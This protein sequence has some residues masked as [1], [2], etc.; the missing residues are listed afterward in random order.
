MDGKSRR[1]VAREFGLARKTISKMLEYSSPPGYRRQK[2]VRRPRLAAWQGVIDAI[3]EE[4][5]RRPKKQRHAAKRIFE[6]LKSEHAY[7]GGYTIMTVYVRQSRIGSQEMFVPLSHAPG[8]AQ[9]DFGEAMVVI[10]DVEQTAHSWCST[11][12][13]PT[14]ALYRHFRPRPRRHFWK[15]TCG[16]SSISARYRHAFSTTTPLWR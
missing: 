10:A 2:S 4:D 14:L 15:V 9:A 1:A 6:R 13:T 8:E 12:P 3:L 5:K 7:P 11:R 16:P